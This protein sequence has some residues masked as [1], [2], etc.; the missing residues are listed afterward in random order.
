M[1][2]HTG[3]SEWWEFPPD[4]YLDHRHRNWVLA[5]EAGDARFVAG[6][7]VVLVHR[8]RAR[9][10]ADA[11]GAG[12]D[13]ARLEDLV[14]L[15][16]T[17]PREPRPR[18]APPP[19]ASTREAAPPAIGAGARRRRR[20]IVGGLGVVAGAA[21]FVTALALPLDDPALVVALMLAVRGGRLILAVEPPPVMPGSGAR[22]RVTQRPS[23]PRE[24]RG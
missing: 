1:K 20:G 10:I 24:R 18:S 5:E 11:L 7:N 23:L 6:G 3:P 9:H 21:V 8:E 16:A 22:P 13:V 4:V 2:H 17:A 15:R 19:G 12:P 14:A